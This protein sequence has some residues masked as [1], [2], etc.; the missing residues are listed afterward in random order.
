MAS[1]CRPLSWDERITSVRTARFTV[2]YQQLDLVYGQLADRASS[3]VDL[4]QLAAYS[5]AVKRLM[6]QG[7]G[8]GQAVQAMRLCGGDLDAAELWI[9]SAPQSACLKCV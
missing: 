3:Q 9:G 1:T 4:T 7:V 5:E 8:E 2:A 6:S